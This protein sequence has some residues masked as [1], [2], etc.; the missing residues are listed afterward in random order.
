MPL[1]APVASSHPE[2]VDEAAPDG[3]VPECPRR[4]P[5]KL[6]WPCCAP[7]AIPS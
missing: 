3:P 7:A 1:D 6:S 5:K 2:L 4:P